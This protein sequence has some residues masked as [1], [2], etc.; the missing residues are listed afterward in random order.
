M[1]PQSIDV[2]IDVTINVD[3]IRDANIGVGVHHS[4]VPKSIDVNID[5]NINVDK[6]Y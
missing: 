4:R 2:N 1:I 6:M 5:V 3:R